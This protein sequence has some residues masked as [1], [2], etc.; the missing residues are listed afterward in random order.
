MKAAH[1]ADSPLV[2]DPFAGGGS[3]PLEALR[4]GC[5]TFASDLN[6]V[7]CLILKVM[8]EDIPRYGA[9]SR[10]GAASHWSAD[11]T[12]GRSRLGDV[13]PEGSGRI[14]AD[15]LPLGADRALRISELRCR[16]SAYALVLAIQEAAPQARTAAPYRPRPWQTADAAFEVFEPNHGQGGAAEHGDAGE[17]DLHGM[18]SG[19]AAEACARQLRTTG[20]GA[21]L[22]FDIW[23]IAPGVRDSSPLSLS[24]HGERVGTSDG[25][26]SDYAAVTSGA[27]RLQKAISRGARRQPEQC[28]TSRLLRVGRARVGGGIQPRSMACSI[29]GDLFTTRQKLSLVSL[30]NY[31]RDSA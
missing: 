29:L 23:G 11:Q 26:A 2:V 3:I 12:A 22:V 16:D 18:L 28:R 17:S 25:S 8:L 20:R 13:L 24:G 7:A 21:D 19:L 6:P 10:R 31:L 27:E 5:E 1:G 15:R 14:D 9:G 4:L 30:S